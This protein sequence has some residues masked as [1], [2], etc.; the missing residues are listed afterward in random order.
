MGVIVAAPGAMNFNA[1]GIRFKTGLQGAEARQAVP[2]I[3]K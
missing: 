1:S 2:G 3:A